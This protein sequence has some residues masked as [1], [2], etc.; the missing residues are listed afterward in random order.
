[1]ITDILS[2]P[3]AQC[4]TF[5]VCGALSIPGRPLAVKTGTSAPYED[6]PSYIGD[7]WAIGYTPDLVVGSWAGNSDNEPMHNISSTNI[8][9]HTVRDFMI[10]FHEGKPVE[11]FTRPAGLVKATACIPS[12][13]KPTRICPRRT[14]EDWFAEAS[15]PKRD[16]DWWKIVDGRR[17]LVLPDNLTPFARSQ[18][19]EWA[20]RIG[21][22]VNI[23]ETGGDGDVS[24]AITNPPANATVNGVQIIGGRAAS[25]GFLSYRIEY[26]SELNPGSWTLI[27]NSANPVPDG[28]LAVWDT[29]PL[30]PGRYTLRIT[31]L[32]RERGDFST[33]TTLQVGPPAPPPVVPPIGPPPEAPPP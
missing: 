24:L 18:A 23:G 26:Q 25:P 16:D 31:L 30:T 1:M 2:D 6:N 29:T 3:N 10:A 11:Q 32:D 17:T 33:T 27:G 20:S 5:G 13:L 19:Q 15:A 12:G 22:T 21:G 8:S 28:P 9:W 7:T 4:I 14:T